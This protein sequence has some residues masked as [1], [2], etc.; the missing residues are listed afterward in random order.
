MKNDPVSTKVLVEDNQ[1]GLGQVIDLIGFTRLH[2][3]ILGLTSF[4]FLASTSQLLVMSVMQKSL[5][6]LYKENTHYIAFLSSS[7]FVGSLLGGFAGGHL[8]DKHGRLFIF[9]TSVGLCATSAA[10]PSAFERP[11]FLLFLLCRF[12]VGLGLA[13]GTFVDLALLAEFMPST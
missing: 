2:L 8:G 10:L 3:L 7:L 9:H 1:L 6:A 5:G 12:L 13:A 4:G 11:P